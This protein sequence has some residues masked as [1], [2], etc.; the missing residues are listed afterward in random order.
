MLHQHR[1][2]RSRYCTWHAS[3]PHPCNVAP[4]TDPSSPHWPWKPPTWHLHPS[5]EVLEPPWPPLPLLQAQ[6]FREGRLNII[7]QLGLKLQQHSHFPTLGG[8]I[9]RVVLEMYAYLFV[10]LSIYVHIYIY[11]FRSVYMYISY[12]AQLVRIYIDD[13]VKLAV[14]NINP[15]CTYKS[16]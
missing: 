1:I 8:A 14:Y 7:R 9:R 10:Y 16:V 5:F 12:N 2:Y 11:I 4:A 6:D 15:N 13:L 3:R